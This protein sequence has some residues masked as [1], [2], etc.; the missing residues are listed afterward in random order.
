MNP[1]LWQAGDRTAAEKMMDYSDSRIRGDRIATFINSFDEG[2]SPF[3]ENLER[4]AKERGIPVIRRETQSFLKTIITALGPGRILEVGCAVGFSTILMAEMAPAG[5]GIIT[6][7]SDPAR[8]REAKENFRKSGFGRNIVISEGDAA[9]ILK[10]LS[11]P[12]DFIFMDAAKGQYVNFLPDVKRL[13]HSGSVLVS[14]NIFQE[15]DIIESHYIVERRNR[16]IYKRMREY[17]LLLKDDKDLETCILP[18]GDGLSLAVM[19]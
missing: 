12:F 10:T 15:G 5:A 8:A 17:L 11:D 9:D 4:S 3:L 7:E 2:N 13:M 6:I 18:V 14:D 19:K 16:T 1:E